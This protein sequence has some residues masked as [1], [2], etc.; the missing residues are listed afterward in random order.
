MESRLVTGC[1]F[2]AIKTARNL[3]E[4][5]KKFTETQNCSQQEIR[6]NVQEIIKTQNWSQI[7][8]LRMELFADDL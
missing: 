6:N 3:Q 2:L 5:C 8:S 7:S 1:C 4:I